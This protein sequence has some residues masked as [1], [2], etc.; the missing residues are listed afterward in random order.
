MMKACKTIIV[1]TPTMNLKDLGATQQILLQDG[2]T[3]SKSVQVSILK[4]NSWIPMRNQNL[5]LMRS[6][7]FWYYLG[8]KYMDS[9]IRS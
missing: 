3:V 7:T 9:D 1:E 2:N 6:E 4:W 8:N 5:E